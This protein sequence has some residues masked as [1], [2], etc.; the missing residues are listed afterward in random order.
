MLGKLGQKSAEE[1]TR[2]G[3]ALVPPLLPKFYKGQLGKILVFGGEFNGAIFFAA[4]AAAKTGADLVHVVCTTDVAQVIKTYS[5][6]L[7]VHPYLL[8]PLDLQLPKIRLLLDKIDVLAIGSGLGREHTTLAAAEIVIKEAIER[9]L[10]IVMDADALYLLCLK[11]EIIKGYSNVILTPNVA[12]FKRLYEKVCG[13]ELPK[14]DG[15]EIKYAGELSRAFGGVTIVQKGTRDVLVRDSEWAINGTPGSN[16]RCGGQGDT[17]CG[18]ISV[19]VAWG[20]KYKQNLWEHD[21]EIKHEWIPILAAYSGGNIVRHA[22]QLG[23][24]EKKRSMQASDL[25][26]KIPEAFE[27]FYGG[28]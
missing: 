7:M 23:Y 14:L 8:G 19:F 10:P 2:L 6:D 25:H 28:K 13:K 9:K 5:P 4:D 27:H 22:S 18:A 17:L 20:E 21:K 3:K 26:Q 12:E 16:R 11:P 15:E 1:L 24:K